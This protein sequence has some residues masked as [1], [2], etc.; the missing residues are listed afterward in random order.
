M[1]RPNQAVPVKVPKVQEL[2]F[3]QEWDPDHSEW[4]GSPHPYVSYYRGPDFVCAKCSAA[5]GDHGTLDIPDSSC[6]FGF[7]KM[8]VCPGDVI[9]IGI[10]RRDDGDLR[11]QL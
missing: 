2:T 4:G 5:A 3:H 6:F 9:S 1:K 10:R 8:I 11:R 7:R